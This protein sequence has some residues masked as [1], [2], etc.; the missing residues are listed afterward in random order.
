M[1]PSGGCVHR[2]WDAGLWCA[3]DDR[4]N[5]IGLGEHPLAAIPVHGTAW[6]LFDFALN[7]VRLPDTSAKSCCSGDRANG[8][9]VI[10]AGRTRANIDRLPVDTGIWHCYS[11][12]MGT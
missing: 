8:P 3:D 6:R 2:C 10:G 5:G 7:K 1:R 4:E 12:Y 9:A 11:P